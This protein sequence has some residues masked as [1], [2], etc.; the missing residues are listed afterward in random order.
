ML[1][2]DENSGSWGAEPGPQGSCHTGLRKWLCSACQ[3]TSRA[4]LRPQHPRQDQGPKKGY[5]K[6]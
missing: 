4:A 2:W 1:N 6:G 3:G 5:R